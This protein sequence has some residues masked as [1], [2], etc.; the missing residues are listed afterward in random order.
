MW[1]LLFANVVGSSHVQQQLPCQ[2]SCRVRLKAQHGR[3]LLLAAC[4]DGAG[5][6]QFAQ[7]G[8]RLACRTVVAQAAAEMADGAGLAAVDRATL[9]RWFRAARQRLVDEAQNRGTTVRE[10]ACT[11][12]LA[13]VG[14]EAAAFGQLG[15]GALVCGRDEGYVPVFWPPATE[16]ANTTWFLSDDD[17]AD[18]VDFA[19]W[20]ARVDEVALLTDGLQ[21]LALHYATQT[22]YAPFFR[23]LFQTL[24]QR[25]YAGQLQTA[26][27]RFLNSPAINGRTDDDKTLILAARIPDCGE[28]TCSS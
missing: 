4:A 25:G 23:P 5:T 26:L 3:P 17:Y 9:L 19:R 1:K 27:R 8:A 16:Y 6:A 13:A 7:D 21:R 12:L 28:P 24:R 14:D 22:A 18:H 2:D 15:D 10:L 11:L 20:P